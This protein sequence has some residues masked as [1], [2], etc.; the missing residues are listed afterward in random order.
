VAY[1]THLYDSLFNSPAMGEIFS[2]RA[3]LQG[4]LDFEAALARAE[5]RVGVISSEHAEAIV[6]KCGAELFDVNALSVSAANAGN[7]AIPLVKA[8]IALVARNNES[9]ARYVHWGATSQDVIDTGLVLQLRQAL[10]FFDAELLKLSNLCANHADTH[11]HT[12]MAGRTWLQHATPIT[13]GLKAAGWLSALERH[14][15][16]IAQCR[17]RVLMMQFGG[18]S[19]T[20]ASLGERGLDVA[21]ALAQEL[22]LDLPELPWH[23]HRDS[24]AETASVLGMLAGT[25]GKIARDISLMMQTEIGEAFEPAGENRGGSSTMPHKRNPVSCAVVLAAATRMPGL[26]STMLS[27][28]VQEHERGLGGW[29][30]EWQTLPHICQLA[31]GALEHSIG[32]LEGL[33]IDAARMG[34]N[35]DLTQGLVLAEAASMALGAQIGHA[36]A[37]HVVEQACQRAIASKRHLRDVLAED[38]QITAHLNAAALEKLFDPKNYTGVAEQ[39][40]D[41]VLAARKP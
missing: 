21:S 25:L 41:R 13:F 10:N 32:M 29:Q 9:A 40:I 24:L 20:L 17:A 5:A 4:M 22:K 38:A 1:S 14:R 19:G 35:L 11:R 26:V 16:R 3:T 15:A 23:S 2:A 18:A 34:A 33:Q 39:F 12:I 31:A 37:H 36:Q 6:T 8:L 27:A 30:A 28:M 7:I